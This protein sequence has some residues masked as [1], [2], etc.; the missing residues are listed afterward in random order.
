MSDTTP[1]ITELLQNNNAPVA[2]KVL[3]YYDGEQEKWLVKILNDPNQGRKDWRSRGLIPRSRNIMKMIIDKSGLLFNDKAPVL[4]VYRNGNTSDIDE[5]TSTLVQGELEKADWIEFFTNFDS[6]VRMLKTACLLVQYDSDTDALTFDILTQQNA[7]VV[8]N[9]NNKLINTL[10]YRTNSA[11]AKEGIFRVYTNV[12]IQDI[13]V[14]ETG[15][16]TILSEEPN[17]FGM[18]PIAAFHDTNIPRIDFWNKIPTDLLNINDIYNL[19]LTDSEYAASWAKLQTLFTNARISAESDTTMQLSEV[20]GSAFPR[21]MPSQS[22]LMGGPGSV[23]QIDTTGVDQ[24]F[25]EYKG[26]V[27]DLAPIDAMV[28]TWIADYAM[29]WSVTVDL[30]GVNGAALRANSGFQ[31]MVEELPNLELRKKRQKMFEA[32]IKRLYKVIIT[33]LNYYKPGCLPEDSNMVACFSDPILPVADT[34]KEEMAWTLRITQG[35][36][37]RVDYFMQLYGL[38]KQDAIAKIA[39]VDAENAVGE[40]GSGIVDTVQQYKMNLSNPSKSSKTVIP[41]ETKDT[42]QEDQFPNENNQIVTTGTKTKIPFPN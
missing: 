39:E 8:Q 31:L 2:Q 17:P 15:E 36:A 5:E 32:G 34:N 41:A 40:I 10:V 16:T 6:V 38:S 18:I 21:F 23:V 12:L 35:R 33:V 19:H 28:K 4:N 30:S 22:T 26:P 11:E 29:D 24:A 20:Y 42:T 1:N 9:P 13:K 14:S 27:V 3:D 25:V 7:A 37:S